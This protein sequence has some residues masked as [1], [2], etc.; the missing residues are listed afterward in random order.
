MEENIR[1]ALE[2]SSYG[3]RSSWSTPQRVVTGVQTRVRIAHSEAADAGSNVNVRT[4]EAVI[5][6]ARQATAITAAALASL[7][8]LVNG[9]LEELTAPSYWAAVT[10][11]RASPLPEVEI[12]TEPERV[13]RVITFAIRVR[14]ALEA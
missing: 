13:G 12:D 8:V 7:E 4:A 14:F 3:V 10:G 5:D 9:Y 6:V 2:A 1:T 11:V